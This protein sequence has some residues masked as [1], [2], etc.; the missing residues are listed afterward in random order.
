MQGFLIPIAESK[1]TNDMFRRTEE[2]VLGCS[3]EKWEINFKS[4][5]VIVGDTFPTAAPT[6]T[7]CS[8]LLPDCTS[9]FCH[10]CRFRGWDRNMG[11]F[12]RRGQNVPL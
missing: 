7:P 10:L 5:Q 11:M 4:N 1:L 2:R 8:L 9:L 12:G 3:A 6:P